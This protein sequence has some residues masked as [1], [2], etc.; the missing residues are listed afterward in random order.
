MCVDRAGDRTRRLVYEELVAVQEV[1]DLPAQEALG[2]AET[3]LA[4]LGYATLR[5]T[6]TSLTVTRERT[7]G[8]P[9]LGVPN[10]TVVALPQSG[11]GV[12]VKVRGNDREGMRERRAD[13]ERWAESLPKMGTPGNADS[14]PREPGHPALSLR[15]GEASIAAEK[16]DEAPA[17]APEAPEVLAEAES[18]KSAPGPYEYTMVPVP[19][20]FAAGGSDGGGEEEAAR[21]LQSLANR[22]AE[23]GWE[24]YRVDTLAS[25]NRLGRLGP[26]SVG[27]RTGGR[28]ATF[29][30]P[31]QF[32]RPVPGGRGA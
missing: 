5:R 13:W 15:E 16:A 29:R 9:E 6:D 10:L 1:V 23:Q 19:L 7:D 27:E 12:R 26:L 30:R 21:W 20:A 32:E 31:T 8:R 17:A 24:F 18:P 2:R 28:V 22:Q 14:A 4:R 3:F 11:A 25:A